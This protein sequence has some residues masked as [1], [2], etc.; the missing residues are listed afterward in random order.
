MKKPKKPK[1]PLK[2][3]TGELYFSHHSVAYIIAE[4]EKLGI[5]LEKAIMTSIDDD[6]AW[7]EYPVDSSKAQ[8]EYEQAMEQYKKDMIAYHEAEISKI[9]DD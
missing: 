1:A 4:L 7:I 9:C 2:N 3:S 6:A 5:P 8:Q